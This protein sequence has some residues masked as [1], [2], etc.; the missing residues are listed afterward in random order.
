MHR[1]Q[2]HLTNISDLVLNMQEPQ[3]PYKNYPAKLNY[4]ITNTIGNNL[5]SSLCLPSD[6][7][8]GLY[9][10][11]FNAASH[12]RIHT[13]GPYSGKVQVLDSFQYINILIS[14]PCM[15]NHFWPLSLC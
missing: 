4:Y 3:N 6:V 13:T 12:L 9:R 2:I 7:Q 8:T 10:K 11:S 5:L 1:T 15:V 14:T